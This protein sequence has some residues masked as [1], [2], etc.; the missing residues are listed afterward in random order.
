MHEVYYNTIVCI[1]VIK[2]NNYLTIPYS[3]NFPRWTVNWH[4][5][6]PFIILRGSELDRRIAL[7]YYNALYCSS[8]VLYCTA[9]HCI[10]LCCTVLHCIVLCCVVLYCIVLHCIVL[11]CIVALHCCIA[12]HCIVLYC[13]VLCCVVLRCIALH[14]TVQYC[15]VFTEYETVIYSLLAREDG[16]DGCND[17]WD[18][19]SW[20]CD[21][22]RY[23]SSH[24]VHPSST[25][26]SD[27]ERYEVGGREDLLQVTFDLIR[28]ASGVPIF[29]A[30]LR[31]DRFC[32]H[33]QLRKAVDLLA[34]VG[35]VGRR[36]LVDGRLQHLDGYSKEEFGKG[37]S[38]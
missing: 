19:D 22:P 12:L 13:I 34:G 32:P 38:T 35:H 28:F 27:S 14:C 9:L 21:C 37:R 5:I 15:I 36:S 2:D 7:M 16:G 8:I 30:A 1:T 6:T 31:C 11:Y 18:D 24:D 20:S 33:Q 3:I 26:A 23:E 29:V 25:A 4:H 17:E 10:V